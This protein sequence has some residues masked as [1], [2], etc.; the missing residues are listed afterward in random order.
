MGNSRKSIISGVIQTVRYEFRRLRVT[1]VFHTKKGAP[2][3]ESPLEVIRRRNLQKHLTTFVTVVDLLEARDVYTANHSKRVTAL[4]FRVCLLLR[5]P[6]YQAEE[7]VMSA[8]IHDIGKVGVPDSILNK[9]GR[10]TE[11][12][13]SAI[14]KHTIIGSELLQKNKGLEEVAQNVR[15]HH[16]RWDGGGY[17]DGIRADEIPKIARIIAVCDSIDAMMTDRPYSKGMS[18][19]MCRSEIRKNTGVMYDP[20][21]AMLCLNNWDYITGDLYHTGK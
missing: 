4:C 3:P 17:P 18:D 5:M 21:I 16:E 6:L 7:T 10:L 1:D 8:A 14:K 19:E 12:E 9:P 2:R 20:Q 13:F 11:E 15:R